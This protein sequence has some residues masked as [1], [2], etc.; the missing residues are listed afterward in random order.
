D[1]AFGVLKLNQVAVARED[2]S[3]RPRNSRFDRAAMS[4]HVRN[5]E[6]AYD[7]ENGQVDITE[8]TDG[9]LLGTNL[10]LARIRQILRILD[11]LI[12]KRFA[13]DVVAVGD[14]VGIL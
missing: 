8:M 1:E 5:V 2:V 3:A 7:N 11:E 14:Q 13:S 9:Q 6:F 4:V 10:E 12:V